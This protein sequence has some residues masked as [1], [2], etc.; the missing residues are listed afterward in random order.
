MSTS[1]SDCPVCSEPFKK[2]EEYKEG[3][4]V[5]VTGPACAKIDSN[6]DSTDPIDEPVSRVFF[7]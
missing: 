5:E 3:T 1:S 7:H 4:S 6:P 2:M